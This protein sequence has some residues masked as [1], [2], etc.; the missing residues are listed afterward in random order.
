VIILSDARCACDPR[1][2]GNAQKGSLTGF[3]AIRRLEIRGSLDVRAL[4]AIT[5]QDTRVLP[6]AYLRGAICYPSS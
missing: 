3:G 6:V 2:S 4:E 5:M 1:S